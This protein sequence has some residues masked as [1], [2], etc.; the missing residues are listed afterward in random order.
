MAFSLTYVAHFDIADEEAGLTEPSGLALTAN[1][2]GLWTVSDDTARIFRL[3]LQG[4]LLP[5]RGFELPVTGLEGITLG[6][7]GRSLYV[8]REESN[9]II[10]L[11]IAAHQVSARRPLAAMAGYQDIAAFFDGEYENKGLEGI[12]WNAESAT[13]FLLKEGKPGLLIEVGPELQTVR[14]HWRLGDQ[15]GFVDAD[16]ES[17]KIDYSGICHDPSRA[18]FWI[19]S[20]KAQR[21]FLYDAAADAVIGSAAL[22]YSEDGK[23]KLIVQ[24]EGVAYDPASSRLYVVGDRDARLFVYDVG[25]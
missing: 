22:T 25:A 16:T 11:D 20:H 5:E 12:A 18:A 3:T 4:S 6:R 19:V 7:A 9:E 2:D 24:A 14:R 10:E 8:V 15:N 1:G 21:V 23:E 17:K 13:L